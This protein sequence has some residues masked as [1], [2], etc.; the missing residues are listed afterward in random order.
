MLPYELWLDIIHRH[1][2]ISKNNLKILLKKYFQISLVS[3]LFNKLSKNKLILWII[4]DELD[5]LNENI[6]TLNFFV[7]YLCFSYEHFYSLTIN[8]Y[9][10]KIWYRN[11]FICFHE[12][13]FLFDAHT[14]QIKFY[15]STKHLK[16]KKYKYMNY[17]HINISKFK[18]IITKYGL[19]PNIHM[20][21]YQYFFDSIDG[22]KQRIH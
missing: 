13:I 5:G 21:Y 10:K 12:K 17:Q 2:K 19:N 3:K 6:N 11:I 7:N 22:K 14:K 20:D 18:K 1:F 9:C 15:L 4:F 16:N 8:Y